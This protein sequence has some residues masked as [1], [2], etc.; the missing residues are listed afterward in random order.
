MVQKHL[1]QR[2]LTKQLL[3]GIILRITYTIINQTNEL[4]N[5]H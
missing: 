1:H 4:N 5:P 2:T 3:A